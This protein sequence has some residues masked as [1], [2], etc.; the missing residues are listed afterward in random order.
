MSDLSGVR[1][2]LIILHIPC[3]ELGSRPEDGSSRKIILDLPIS[4]LANDNLRLFPP[5]R[6]LTNFPFSFIKLQL[7]IISYTF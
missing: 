4:A 6:F 3:L 7:Y 1:T 5:D 2:D